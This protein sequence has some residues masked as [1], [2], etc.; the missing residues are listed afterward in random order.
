[1]NPLLLEMPMLACVGVL[2]ASLPRLTPNRLYF[3]VPVAADFRRSE[4]A[5]RVLVGY[6]AQVL[7]WL[8]LAVALKLW[9]PAPG[10]V[11]APIG[12]LVFGVSIAFVT[13]HRRVAPYR[14]ADAGIREAEL[15]GADDRLPLWT[16]LAL[17]PFAILGAAAFYLREN[18]D[19]IPQRFPVHWGAD[20][21]PDRWVEKTAHG[22]YGPLLF[23]AGIIVTT[24][25]LAGAA[26]YGARRSPARR[27]AL[28]CLIGSAWMLGLTFSAVALLPVV[29]VP[30]WLIPVLALAFV[31]GVIVLAFR[32]SA[33][34]GMPMEHT[35]DECWHAAVIYYNPADPAL[36]VQKRFGFGYTFN[37]GNRWSWVI[38]S[39]L[40]AAMALLTRLLA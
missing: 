4:P 13:S 31:T 19:R 33:T 28:A 2:L 39:L 23:G 40:I 16:W 8:A 9:M 24:L 36:F 35:A 3:G 7:F 38:L 20:G 32:Q 6:E 1:M 5:R 12:L 10:S 11:A 25:L 14:D 37:F 30:L 26:F 21:T 29:K 27:S 17:P 18:W 34:A 22:V 15:G